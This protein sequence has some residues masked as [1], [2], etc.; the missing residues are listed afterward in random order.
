MKPDQPYKRHGDGN[1]YFATRQGYREQTTPTSR[2]VTKTQNFHLQS[3]N[4]ECPYFF[5]N[6]QF[7][8]PPSHPPIHCTTAVSYEL[9]TGHNHAAKPLAP[10]RTEAKRASL[11]QQQTFET[12]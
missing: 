10:Q 2:Q 8:S 12:C 5:V 3:R 6:L 4:L 1:P 7:L 11:Y 9:R